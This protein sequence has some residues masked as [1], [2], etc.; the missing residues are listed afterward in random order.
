MRKSSWW[1]RWSQPLATIHN[2]PEGQ[3]S[4]G[5]GKV[6]FAE[7]LTALYDQAKSNGGDSFPLSKVADLAT[8]RWQRSWHTKQMAAGRSYPPA[9]EAPEVTRQQIKGWLQG[10]KPK[11]F[12]G[13]LFTVAVLHDRAGNSPLDAK[14]GA[15]E[16]EPEWRKL[17]NAIPDNKNSRM[18]AP[19]PVLRPASGPTAGH[20]SR[21]WATP[22]FRAT[23]VLI[24]VAAVVVVFAVVRDG[25]E[26][27]ASYQPPSGSA[28]DGPPRSAAPGEEPVRVLGVTVPA[29]LDDGTEFATELPLELSEPELLELDRI[30]GDTIAL[31]EWRTTRDLIPV[32]YAAV[33]MVLS[34]GGSEA[35][36][37]TNIEAIKKCQ[38]PVAGTYLKEYTQGGA[39]PNVMIGIDLDKPNAVAREIVDNEPKGAAFFQR[40]TIPLERDNRTTVT[41]GAFTKRSGC[42]FTVRVTSSTSAGSFTQMID[43]DGRPFKVTAVAAGTP[44][45]PLSGYSDAYV[46]SG[47]KWVRV[48]PSVYVK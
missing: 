28:V 17:Y 39:E 44:E 47:L 8:E 15:Q 10:A 16:Y 43:N 7:E 11:S 18:H 25:G 45:H 3:L 29:A 6:R 46:Q 20:P 24:V 12:D 42:E 30:Q 32:G 19:V 9:S 13:L 23:A 37:V 33:T 31:T 22:A 36:T 5:E 38:D 4:D 35:V 26:D 27:N 14:L 21:R 41:L 2:P 48:D 1:F 34:S 40:G